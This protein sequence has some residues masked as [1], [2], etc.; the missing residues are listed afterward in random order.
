MPV[1]PL[2]YS[3]GYQATWPVL[4]D[5]RVKGVI[6]LDSMYSSAQP[7]I[8]FANRA[9]APFVSLTVGPSTAKHAET[10][11]KGVSKGNTAVTPMKGGHGELVQT[12]LA[13]VL[14]TLSVDAGGKPLAG[15]S[16]KPA[17]LSARAPRP[18]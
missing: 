7:F 17:Q 6:A 8:D 16:E 2:T 15:V 9:D 3:G 11:E 14:Q 12:A 5:S 18:G 1:V 13:D 4:K 10:F